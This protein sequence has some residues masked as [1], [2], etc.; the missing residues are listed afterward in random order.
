VLEKRILT[1]FD[2]KSARSDQIKDSNPALTGATD[3]DTCRLHQLHD[4]FFA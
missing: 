1:R 2:A 4:P 3:F